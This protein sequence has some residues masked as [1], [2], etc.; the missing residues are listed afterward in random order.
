MAGPKPLPR[1]AM[2]GRLARNDVR[3]SLLG[4]AEIRSPAKSAKLARSAAGGIENVCRSTGGGG[5]VV[6]LVR[7][8][9]TLARSLGAGVGQ[10]CRSLEVGGGQL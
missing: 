6:K 1:L 4:D 2:G 8:L 5:G 10:L 3:D 7:S 9:G